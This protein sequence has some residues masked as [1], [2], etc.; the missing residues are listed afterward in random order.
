MD[1]C[2]GAYR[3]IPSTNKLRL[4][5]SKFQGGVA[6]WG[7]VEPVI[8]TSKR[9]VE[10]GIHV[11][12]R[13]EAGAKKK[14]ID[15]NF[16]AVELVVRENLLEDRKSVMIT[17]DTAVAYYLCRF[18]DQPLDSLF[19][20]HCGT[21]HLDSDWFAVKPHRV[22]LCHKCNQLFRAG[23][24][25]ISNPLAAAQMS[26]GLPQ[27][28]KPRRAKK[29]LIVDSADFPGGFQIWASNPA[30]LWTSKLREEEGIHVHAWKDKAKPA[31]DDTFAEV[32]ID[33][34]QLNETQLRTF[35]AQQSLYYLR[36]KVHSINCPYCT[37]PHFDEGVAAF[38]PTL[39]KTCTNCHGQFSFPNR[40][41]LF[42]SNPF[43]D[44]VSA[45]THQG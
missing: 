22:H 37:E 41:K 24:K 2:E 7:A 9:R 13:L 33:G 21:P 1:R 29:T 5:P 36:G 19:C 26:L 11:H 43:V 14:A 12:A 42:V 3:T 32:V 15:R 10:S 39:E 40:R 23:R 18:L 28:R 27:S 25:S 30:I 34:I 17:R 38:R 35:M 31:E 44:T 6:L 8:N 16:D 4:D 45:L 20:P